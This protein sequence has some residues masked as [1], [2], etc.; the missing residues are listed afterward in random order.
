MKEDKARL[1]NR[2]WGGFA[3]LAPDHPAVLALAE[4]SQ[5][6]RLARGETVVLESDTDGTVYLVA[7]GLLR[8]VRHTSN[9][10]E[11]WYADIKPGELTGDMAALTG[12]RRT[13]T[14]VAKS[15]ATVF[16]VQ[17]EA[18]LAVAS[19]F[20][21]FTLALARMLALRLQA[22]STHLAE[23]AALPVSSRV[24][25]ELAAMGAPVPG[26]SEL[27]E[28]VSPPSVMAL[29]Q[30]IHA[31]REATSRALGVLAE[32]GYLV[33]SRNRWQVIV[34]S[35]AAAPETSPSAP[36]RQARRQT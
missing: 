7:S 26:D 8:A 27:F 20:P 12:G 33:R 31:T 21:E 28:I 2:L 5:L 22:T 16:A 10:H 6:R 17:Q 34:P 19:R 35:H 3:G 18:F 32:R 36:A 29:S 11:V 30:R 24:H 4:A 1:V 15:L 9:G 13:S 25:G 23:L 14:V